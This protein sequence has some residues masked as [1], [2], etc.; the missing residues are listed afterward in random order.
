MKKSVVILIYLNLLLAFAASAL[1]AQN[2]AKTFKLQK[3]IVDTILYQALEFDGPCVYALTKIRQFKGQEIYDLNGSVFVL[4]TASDTIGYYAHSCRVKTNIGDTLM[5]LG[6]DSNDKEVHPEGNHLAGIAHINRSSNV[7][8][9]K[10][11]YYNYKLKQYVPFSKLY[12]IK[13]LSFYEIILLDITNK[14]WNRSFYFRKV[15]L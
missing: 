9:V 10:S 8:V 15:R 11:S 1:H 12:K 6:W 7:I 2:K 5:N 13:K 3:P 4:W 14:E